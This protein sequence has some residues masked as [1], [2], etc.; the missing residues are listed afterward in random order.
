[1]EYSYIVYKNELPGIEYFK[2]FI[3]WQEYFL[4]GGGGTQQKPVKGII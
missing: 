3:H 1:M 4:Q 2:H